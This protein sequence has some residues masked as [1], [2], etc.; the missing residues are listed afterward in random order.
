MILQEREPD[1]IVDALKSKYVFITKRDYEDIAKKEFWPPAKV[2]EQSTGKKW[3]D[4][5]GETKRGYSQKFLAAKIENFV[6][7]RGFVPD[8][9]QAAENGFDL[10]EYKKVFGSWAKALEY[11]NMKVENSKIVSKPPKDGDFINYYIQLSNSLGHLAQVK[12]IENDGKMHF[13]YFIS[14]TPFRNLAELRLYIANDSRLTVMD[15]SNFCIRSSHTKQKIVRKLRKLAQNMPKVF[16]DRD[17]LD[18]ILKRNSL[19]SSKHLAKIFNLDNPEDIMS[20]LE[21]S[22][23]EE[24]G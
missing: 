2:I 11:C 13:T 14:N 7:D 19:P 15:E 1:K 4:L 24:D 23:K 21:Q 6:Y 12:D 16:D 5:L 22:K 20:I 10:Y 8:A 9:E 18:Q 3:N 17:Q